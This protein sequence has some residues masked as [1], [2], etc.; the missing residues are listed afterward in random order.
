MFI[1]ERISFFSRIL[2]GSQTDGWKR[3]FELQETRTSMR[4]REKKEL[5]RG[6]QLRRS[7]SLGRCSRDCPELFPEDMGFKMPIL[8][9]PASFICPFR[10]DSP[11]S[12]STIFPHDEHLHV[13]TPLSRQKDLASPA[14]LWASGELLV[15][16]N[17]VKCKI[18]L[19]SRVHWLVYK[20][21]MQEVLVYFFTRLSA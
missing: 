7:I 20:L 5:V 13:L 16:Y 9:L 2:V 4:L 3:D 18:L 21:Q 11:S 17:S 1:P 15:S 19:G 6:T 10:S 8:K 12:P 14:S